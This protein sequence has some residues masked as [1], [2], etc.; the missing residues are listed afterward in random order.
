L[1]A[2]IA[3]ARS[4]LSMT[5]ACPVSKSVATARNAVGSSSKLAVSLKGSV[6]ERSICCSF[7]P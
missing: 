2:R 4:P 3:S 7:W 1:V 6:T 5:T